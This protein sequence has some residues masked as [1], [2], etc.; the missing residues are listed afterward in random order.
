MKSSALEERPLSFSSAT[1]FNLFL[2]AGLGAL[3][4]GGC[5]YLGVLLSSLPAGAMLPG[6][7]GLIQVSAE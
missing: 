4:L 3:N 6:G 5:L 2:A 7:Y 1:G